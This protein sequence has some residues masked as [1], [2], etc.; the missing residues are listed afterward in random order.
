[1]SADPNFAVADEFARASSHIEFPVVGIG[2]SAGGIGAL[3]KLFE[4]MPQHSGMAFVV[5]L[6]LSPKHESNVDSILR[7]VTRMPVAQV[8]QTTTI[9]AD[10][11]Y[12]ISPTCSLTMSDGKLIVS[13]AE[14]PR[15]RH[16]AID[17]FFRTLADVHRDRSVCLVLSGTGSDGAVGLRRIKERGGVTLVQSPG[18]AEYDGMPLS[19]IGTG[20]VD[21]VLPVIDMPAKLTDIWHNAQRI[22][23]PH[24]EHTG[25]RVDS[26]DSAAAATRAEE[27]LAD[28]MVLLRA[29]TGARLPP[30]QARHRAAPARAAHAGDA[31]AD[32]ADLPRL[33]RAPPRRDRL[34]AERPAHQRHQLLSRP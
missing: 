18:D 29:R 10:H 3:L 20:A 27:A 11:I 16:V 23:L 33:P 19:A 12:V 9:E 21:F 2:A 26:P 5:I 6:H 31:G 7:K 14:R 24:P 34:A 25:L 4:H 22:E 17:L 30:L 8:N 1:M 15:G 28:V 13:E 32:L